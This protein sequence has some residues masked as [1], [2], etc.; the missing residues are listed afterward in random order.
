MWRCRHAI[1]TPSGRDFRYALAK[2]ESPSLWIMIAGPYSAP[3]AAGRAANARRLNQAAALVW[4]AGHVPIIGVN[5]AL[6][7]IDADKRPNA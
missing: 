6:P 5:L 2:T 1:Q 3:D 7:I 4:A